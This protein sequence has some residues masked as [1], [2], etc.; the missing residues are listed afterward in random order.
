MTILA[1]LSDGT[2]T[3]GFRESQVLAIETN[4][5]RQVAELK[6]IRGKSRSQLLGYGL[7]T[8]EIRARFHRDDFSDPPTSPDSQLAGLQF[9]Y[10]MEAGVF[11]LK[12]GT[13]SLG[14]YVFENLEINYAKMNGS[15]IIMADIRVQLIEHYIAPS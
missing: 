13:K 5:Q 2:N 7:K 15:T 1:T 3:F 4:Q 9:L 14:N 12:I 10:D 8:A 11:E 6:T